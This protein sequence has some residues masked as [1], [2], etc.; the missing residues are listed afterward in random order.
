LLGRFRFVRSTIY[1]PKVYTPNVLCQSPTARWGPQDN[2]LPRACVRAAPAAAGN[3][4]NH[5]TV[6]INVH[7]SDPKATAERVKQEL[8]EG[9]SHALNR[10]QGE[11]G[12]LYRSPWDS[13]AS[14]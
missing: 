7:G 5:N 13:G 11:A 12:G 8:V 9:L 1:N 2:P 10:N 3:T 14:R 4:T 6:T